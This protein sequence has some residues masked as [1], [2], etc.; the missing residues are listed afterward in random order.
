MEKGEGQANRR[1]D[2]P[3]ITQI[4]QKHLGSKTKESKP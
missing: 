3:Q 2:Y 4:T 1:T